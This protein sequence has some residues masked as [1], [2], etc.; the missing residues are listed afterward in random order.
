[1]LE[2][3]VFDLT[4]GIFSMEFTRDLLPMARWLRVRATTDLDWSSFL[5]PYLFIRETFEHAETDLVCL[6]DFYGTVLEAALW[7]VAEPL[8]L[9]CCT[10]K[11][12]WALIL[13]FSMHV[14]L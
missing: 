6:R 11:L 12:T 13:P 14:V 4:L 3:F 2:R 9:L 8:L 10:S 5:L 1:L 7:L